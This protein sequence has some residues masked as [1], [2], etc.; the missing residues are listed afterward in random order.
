MEF[1]RASEKAGET[2]FEDYHKL[3]VDMGSMLVHM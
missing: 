1:D 2:M 3:V